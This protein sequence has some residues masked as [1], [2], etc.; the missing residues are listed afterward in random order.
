MKHITGLLSIIAIF[1]LSLFACEQTEREFYRSHD[2][3]FITVSKSQMFTE[4]I[5]P[6]LR[7]ASVEELQLPT[8]VG[9][10]TGEELA[11]HQDG[12]Y[13]AYQYDITNFS[14]TYEEYS[15][16]DDEQ[17]LDLS[18]ASM[19]EHPAVEWYGSVFHDEEHAPFQ[20][21]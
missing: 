2:R 19:Q 5:E 7:Q 8:R 1:L 14:G 17:G 9:L 10:V 20:T 21:R 4:V 16:E 6:S 15:E 3:Q 13:L 12:Y 18:G 11:A